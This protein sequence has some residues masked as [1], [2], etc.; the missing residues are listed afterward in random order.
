MTM[1]DVTVRRANGSTERTRLQVARVANLGM[2]GRDQSNEAVEAGIRGMNEVGVETPSELP[3]VTPKPN[4]LLTT[5]NAIQVNTTRTVGEAEFVLFPTEEETYLGVGNDHKD[6]ELAATR[7]HAANST[8]PSV[9][10]DEV[11]ALEDVR[12]HWDEIRL[13]SW[14]EREGDL[15]PYQRASLSSFVEPDELIAAVDRSITAPVEGTAIWSGTV[16]DDGV[17]PFPE[18]VSGDFYLVRLYDPVLERR[19][20]AHYEVHVNDWVRDVTLE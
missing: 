10:G 20:I 2:A 3:F 18:L 4:S 19:L 6:G 1:I 17:D 13:R 7:M 9:V 16:G 8:C 12:D 5:A 15:E 14:V 11:W